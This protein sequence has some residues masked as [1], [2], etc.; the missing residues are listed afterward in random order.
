MHMQQYLGAVFIHF[1]RLSIVQPRIVK[2][3]VDVIDAFPRI[4]VV[5]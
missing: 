1:W 3:Q 4:Q 5:A 2:H